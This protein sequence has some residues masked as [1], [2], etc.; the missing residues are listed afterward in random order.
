MNY[1]SVTVN[2][3]EYNLTEQADFTN[4]QLTDWQTEEGIAEFAANGTDAEGNEVRV[5]WLQKSRDSDLDWSQGE[6]VENL[7]E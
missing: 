4:R 1:G 7:G 3:V 2:G 6:R 5:Y